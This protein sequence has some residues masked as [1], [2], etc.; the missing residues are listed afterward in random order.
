[1][2]N[3]GYSTMCGHGI[4]AVAT[5]VLETG[6]LSV[7][8]PE[9]EIRIDTPAGMISARATIQNNAVT[10]VSFL[11][12]PSYVLALDE[13]ITI[14]GHGKLRY[15]LAFGGA[16]YA[17]VE[18]ADLGL[19]CT[20]EDL[21]ELI[22]F[23]KVIKQEVSNVTDLKHPF[24]KDMNFLY[25]IIFIDAPTNANS[26]SRNVCIFADGEVDRSPTGTGISGRMAIRNA[27]NQSKVN[28]PF[29]VES[30]LGS[31]FTGKV[32]KETTF[33]PHKAVVPEIS[34]S[35][36]I[37]GKQEFFI[38]PDDPLNSGFIFR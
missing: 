32:I 30:I 15:D 2:H 21:E 25:G 26:H 31:T 18:A 34:G 35:A 17:Y 10:R 6:M 5:V 4:I 33:G 14:P 13:V 37:T 28:E 9:T 11:N 16:Y 7:Q 3:E 24:E 36:Y 20:P 12:V 1:M 38:N 23:G 22:R 19:S 29:I 27:R 8:E